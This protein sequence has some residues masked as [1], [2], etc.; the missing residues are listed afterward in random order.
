[1]VSQGWNFYTNSGIGTNECV[2][3]FFCTHFYHALKGESTCCEIYSYFQ[4]FMCLPFMWSICRPDNC[5]SISFFA[6]DPLLR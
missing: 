1:M 2:V 5:E 6:F 4:S 3:L